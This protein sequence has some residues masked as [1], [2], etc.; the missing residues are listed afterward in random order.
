V[1]AAVIVVAWETETD[2]GGGE[3]RL[4]FV[5]GEAYDLA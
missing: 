3:A 2:F 4:D 1:A 5:V